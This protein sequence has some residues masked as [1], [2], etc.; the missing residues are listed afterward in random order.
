MAM[1]LIGM[2]FIKINLNYVVLI[3]L[4]LLILV[5]FVLIVILKKYGIKKYREIEIWMILEYIK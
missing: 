5:S 2:F 4:L 1:A 3:Q